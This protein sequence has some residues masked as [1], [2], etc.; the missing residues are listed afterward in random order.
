MY[1]K[2][3]F[4]TPHG[5]YELTEWKA[6]QSLLEICRHNLIPHQSVSFY[7]KT[8]DVFRNLIGIHM[9]L[10]DIEKDVSVV[11]IKPD[12]NIDYGQICNR[13]IK[14]SKNSNPSSEYTFPSKD[15]NELHHIELTKEMCHDHVRESVGIFFKTKVLIHAQ[16]KLVIGVSGGGDS[17]TLIK[18]FLESGQVSKEQI[19]AVMMLG[20]PDWDRGA[21]RAEELC[22]NHGVELRFIHA[23]QINRLLGRNNTRSW[24]EDF[25]EVFP[26]ADLEVLGTHCIRLALT[27]VAKEVNAQAIVTGLNLED[28]LAECFLSVINGKLPPP[29]PVRV[30]DNFPFWYPLYSIPKKILDGC[31]PKYALENYNDRYPSRMIGRAI[32]YYLSQM[33]HPILPGAEFDLLSGFEK[34]AE[35]NKH[36]GYFEKDLGFTT[37]MPIE[38]ALK[39]RWKEFVG[40]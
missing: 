39:N 29:F 12:R 17:N 6:E 38:P 7:C 4:S 31:Y 35:S 15:G 1:L 22:N 2:I 13:L 20:I 26:D 30:I 21:K 11:I 40:G 3:I 8:S 9:P 19:V 34:L 23:E 16:R 37:V 33:I 28:I 25:E 36:H 5:D 24:V 27:H 14:I 32:P 10:K 18:S